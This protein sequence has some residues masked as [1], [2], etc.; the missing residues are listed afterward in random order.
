MFYVYLA[1]RLRSIC[2]ERVIVRFRDDNLRRECYVGE[3]DAVGA[4]GYALRLKARRH[5]IAEK[6]HEASANRCF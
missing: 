1:M 2:L 3:N 6:G 5:C 4:S